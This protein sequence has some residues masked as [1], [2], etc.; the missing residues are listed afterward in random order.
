MSVQSRSPIVWVGI[1]TKLFS[2][3]RWLVRLRIGMVGGC[4]ILSLI[5]LGLQ[6]E[7]ASRSY[8]ADRDITV[9]Y[10]AGHAVLRGET[11]YSQGI[12]AVEVMP[13]HLPLWQSPSTFL[14]PPPAAVLFAGVAA[15]APNNF[16]MLWVVILE[17]CLFGFCYCIVWIAGRRP[18]P[19]AA[20]LLM[21]PLGISQLY[22]YSFSTGQIDILIFLGV[23]GAALLALYNRPHFTAA[24]L[25]VVA[26]LK[27]YPIFLL[28][29]IWRKF[30]W[31]PMIT[32]GVTVLCLN[33]LT[34][35]I[36]GWSAYR[37]FLST[38]LPVVSHP[39][40]W[41]GNISFV[42]MFAR[43]N[44]V[45]GLLDPN[46]PAPQW[47]RLL[48]ACIT[49][50]VIAAIVITTLRK[51]FERSYGWVAW[52]SVM[53]GAICWVAYWTV[54]L[55]PAA[56]IWRRYV[57]FRSYNIIPLDFVLLLSLPLALSRFWGEHPMWG[58]LAALL[59]MSMIWHVA[60]KAEVSEIKE[61]I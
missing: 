33:I 9:F 10:N 55:V 32:A 48:G 29:P 30:G 7:V 27:L 37:E 25:A 47:L 35:P 23:A 2:N 51:P 44:V 46:V 4:L 54:A 26:C 34:L 61:Q 21:G 58:A 50:M 12:K 8:E 1:V 5:Q 28:L 38:V 36:L 20:F 3:S 41:E 39:T 57:S 60:R 15:L 59:L 24:S 31:K 56:F 43:I 40:T 13:A 11:P 52:M 17:I 49:L 42:S 45:L 16:H 53:A 6:T 18:N 19:L 22:W 14:Y